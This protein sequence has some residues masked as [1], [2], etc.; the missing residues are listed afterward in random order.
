M[1]AFGVVSY[2][3]PS[4]ISIY[5]DSFEAKDAIAACIDDYNNTASEETR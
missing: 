1:E 2:D 5:S 3:A 4:S